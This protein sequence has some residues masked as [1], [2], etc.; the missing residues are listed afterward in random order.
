MDASTDS[1]PVY[2]AGFD[3]RAV[4]KIVMAAFGA[5][6]T[7]YALHAAPAFDETI[8]DT[9]P[10]DIIDDWKAQDGADYGAAIQKIK[11]SLAE[12]Y[13]SLVLDGSTEADYLRACHWR[14]VSR[15]KPFADRI[16]RIIYGRHHDIGGPV[17]GYT[18]DLKGDGAIGLGQWSMSASMSSD[19]T[20]GNANGTA[21]HLLEFKD[22]YPMPRTVL[23][24]SSGVLRDPCVSYD[25]N[26][27][28]VAWSKDRDGYHLYEL[29]LDNPATPH[30]LTDDPSGLTVS[31]FEPCYLPNGDIVFNSSRNFS[32]VIANINLTSNLF[33]INK[34]GN[35]LRRI[36]Y[37]Q[38]HTFYP[39]MMEDGGVLYSRADN[40]DR[41]DLRFGLFCMH[42]DGTHQTEYFGNQL[43]VSFTIPQARQIPGTK[44]V[45]AII[46]GYMG[47]YAGALAIIDPEI[48]R[49]DTDAITMV[50]P[51]GRVLPANSTEDGVPYEWKLFQNPFPLS[52]E[53]FLISW[54]PTRAS[55]FRIVLMNS[56]GNH[57]LLAWA[58][59]Q[60]VSQPMPV[61]ARPLPEI[62]SYQADYSKKTASYSVTDVY[63]GEGLKGLAVGSIKKIRVIALEYRTDPAFGNTGTSSFWMTPVGRFGS[64]MNAKRILGEIPVAADGS[65]HFSV[66][67]PTPVFFQLIGADGSMIQTMQSWSTLM[68]G[69]RFACLGCH[70]DNN[71][72][73]PSDIEI[74][75]G[76]PEPFFDIKNDY[77]YYPRHIQPILDRNCVKGGCH[78][79]SHK[80]LNLV[81]TPVNTESLD[82]DSKNACRI[83][84]RSYHNLSNPHYCNYNCLM[85]WPA[86][87][88][89]G[90]FG[91][92]KSLVITQLREGHHDVSL[93]EEEMGRLCAWIDLGVPHSGTYTDDMR[94]EDSAA[95]EARLDRRRRHEQ[96]EAENIAE[97]IAAGG[98]DNVDYGGTVIMERGRGKAPGG[99]ASASFLNRSRLIARFSPVT[100]HLS[101]LP[102][103]EGVV[104]VVDLTGRLAARKAIGRR[105]FLESRIVWMSASFPAGVYVVRFKGPAGIIERMAALY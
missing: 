76:E 87:R 98:Y 82:G 104:T 68:P 43:P 19:Y 5:F 63:K 55:R 105:E 44:K 33:I 86:D 52:E 99:E 70:E 67:A 102:P 81:G 58:D 57:E 75:A 79:S 36:G 66:P 49:N 50:A 47:P 78:D 64:T 51:R 32:M 28:A 31:D 35:Y 41:T 93:T 46:G 21:I 30:Q 3:E 8:P 100:K 48:S 60:S 29:S 71:A 37:D 101:I 92:A 1:S 15:I 103:S 13:A 38:L 39:T 34:D 61:A 59:G 22:Y 24:D 84:L 95:Y 17:V 88:T 14:R 62:P 7:V 10:A 80:K 77:L 69:E 9:I 25:G 83:W 27:I 16:G 23:S 74:P 26:R 40:M 53:W 65:V 73:Q 85:G 20:E 45:L 54:R 6:V 90:S 11:A 96:F 89:P 2:F 12:P 72:T 91:S 18:E 97:F 4:R 94:P 42:P 56:D